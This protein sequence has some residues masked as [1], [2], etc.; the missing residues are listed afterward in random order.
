MDFCGSSVRPYHVPCSLFLFSLICHA[1][2]RTH[3]A[4]RPHAVCQT[5]LICSCLSHHHP[6]MP[7]FLLVENFQL[8]SSNAI[9]VVVVGFNELPT[10]CGR[11]AKSMQLPT[12]NGAGESISISLTCHLRH[13]GAELALV[14]CG[15]SI[16]Y[17]TMFCVMTRNIVEHFS[18]S[19]VVQKSYPPIFNNAP[20]LVN[21]TLISFILIIQGEK[22]KM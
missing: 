13:Y 6:A 1:P 22:I 17:L 8:I 21:Q 20:K 14:R 10:D 12:P 18:S 16:K 2:A 4:A 15:F 19:K 9:A 7:L 5:M 11:N 3:T